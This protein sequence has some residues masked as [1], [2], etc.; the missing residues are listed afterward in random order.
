M[1][2]Q[3]SLQNRLAEHSEQI[4]PQ[5]GMGITEYMWS[6]RN[7]GTI[8]GISKTGKTIEFTY[9]TATR[10]DDNGYYG[11]QEYKYETNLD[12]TVYKARQNKKGQW[13]IINGTSTIGIGFRSYHYDVS[14]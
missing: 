6:D 2:M 4:T 7:V 9:D 11:R 10:I 14:F 8:V 12:G 5:I 3:G 13:K 1:K